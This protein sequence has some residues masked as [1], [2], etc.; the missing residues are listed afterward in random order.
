VPNSAET[1]SWP[2]CCVMLLAPEICRVRAGLSPG[3]AS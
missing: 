1:R 3:G 2:I